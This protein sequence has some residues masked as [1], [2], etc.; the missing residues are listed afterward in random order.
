M[1]SKLNSN[2]YS[3]NSLNKALEFAVNEI[4][5]KG[6]VVEIKKEKDNYVVIE[7]E[8]KVKIKTSI[9]G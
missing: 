7:I 2:D 6:N 5:K 3:N 9:T 8:R 4:L 1:E